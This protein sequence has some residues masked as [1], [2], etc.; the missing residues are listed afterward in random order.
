M[1]KPDLVL[2]DLVLIGAG[3]M[4]SA[5]A[6]GWLASGRSA[7]SFFAV[8]PQPGPAAK[9][10]AAS[11]VRIVPEL[12]AADGAGLK[13]LVLAVKPQMLDTVAP[14]LVAVLPADAMVLSILAGRTLERLGEI[15]GAGRPLVRA[16]PNTPAAVGKGYSVY[17]AGPRTPR[18]RKDEARRLLQA[19][20]EAAELDSENQMDAATAVSGSGPAYFFLMTE[21][22][23]AAGMQEGLPRDLAEALAR[24]TMIGSGALMESS[25]ESPSRLRE[26]VTS[27]R[28]TT[29]A[30]MDVLNQEHG[31]PALLRRAVA[32]AAARSRELRN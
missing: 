15:F 25:E 1:T 3:R 5:L 23:A 6:A 11:G 16:M 8:D 22:L 4:G 14:A 19:C 31:L 12:T 30:A 28:G 2:P 27:P 9:A 21:A 18:E 32:A 7:D 13:T 26:G 20:G 24:A 10:L 17:V 29:A